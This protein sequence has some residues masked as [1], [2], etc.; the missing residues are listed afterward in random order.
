[1][2][3]LSFCQIIKEIPTMTLIGCGVGLLALPP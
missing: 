1:M 3:Y 2:T